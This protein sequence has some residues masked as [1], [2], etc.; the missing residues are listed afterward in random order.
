M[1]KNVKPTDET[2]TPTS[3]DS[4]MT[5]MPENYKMDELKGLIMKNKPEQKK[6]K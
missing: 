4:Q 2:D 5:R 3:Y 1:K 6:K